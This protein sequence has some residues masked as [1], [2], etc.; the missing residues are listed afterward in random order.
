MF[1]MYG[2]RGAEPVL[3]LPDNRMRPE[4][5]IEPLIALEKNYLLLIPV[6]SPAEGAESRAK[7]METELLREYHLH[8]AGAYGI[9]SGGQALLELLRLGNVYIRGA[10][11]EG[12]CGLPDRL[13][14]VRGKLY[15]WKSAACREAKKECKELKKIFPE[16]RTLTMKKLKKGQTFLSVRPDLMVKQLDKCFRNPTEKKGLFRKKN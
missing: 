2:K 9:G 16:L 14:N 1:L 3:L 11:V 6:F 7:A 12:P 8:L 5:L 15:Y 10:V 13:D 4:E